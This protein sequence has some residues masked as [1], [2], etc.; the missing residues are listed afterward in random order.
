M[1]HQDVQVFDINHL[2]KTPEGYYQGNVICTGVGVFTYLDKNGKFVK[3]L[4]DVDDVK[5]ATSTLNCIP[6]TLN[7]PNEPVTA[8]NVDDY[9][10]GMTANDAS[11]DGLNNHVTVTITGK[12]AIEAIDKKE[13][14]AFSMGYKCNVIDNDGV[15]QGVHHD[16]QQKNIGYNHFALVKKGRAGDK[17]RF[18]VGD[19]ADFADFFDMADPETEEPQKHTEDG[20][21]HQDGQPV[22]VNDGKAGPDVHLKDSNNNN[23]EQSMK[24]IQLDG[25]DYQAD[26]KVIDA[27]QVAQKDAAEKLDEIHTLLSAVDEKDSQIADLKEQLEKANDEIDESVIDAAVNAKLEIL[28]AARAAGIECDTSDDVSDLKRK[29]IAAAF[30]GIDIESIEDETS[31]NA[32]YMSANKVIADRAEKGGCGGKGGTK[33]NPASQFDGAREGA[34]DE[35]ENDSLEDKLMRET[36]ALSNGK[37]KEV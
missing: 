24:T 11:F 30:D 7:H 20:K 37:K 29:V 15:W 23:Q 18:V 21:E 28:D 36:I 14:K 34:A 17:V 3:R 1:F 4:R 31:I 13:V 5:K 19:S 26:E 8:D 10:V 22:I 35:Y 27:L 16:Q 32:L 33:K 12:R 6:V 9:Q 2:H 25:V